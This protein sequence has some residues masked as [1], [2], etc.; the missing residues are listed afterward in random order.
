MSNQLHRDLLQELLPPTVWIAEITAVYESHIA[1]A[2]LIQMISLDRPPNMSPEVLAQRQAIMAIAARMMISM[3]DAKMNFLCS[4]WNRT[5]MREDLHD[6][7]THRSTW[8][9]AIHDL[10][11]SECGTAD[12]DY[13]THELTAFDRAFDL[14]TPLI[15]GK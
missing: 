15:E 12:R 6:F 11:Q 10:S 14:L 9:S 3:R 5:F 2:H 1:A 13:W 8:R 4:Q 7:I